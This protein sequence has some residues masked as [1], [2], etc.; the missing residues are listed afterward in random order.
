[1]TNGTRFMDLLLKMIPVW[2]AELLM[3]SDPLTHTLRN[4]IGQVGRALTSMWT[5]VAAACL[6]VQ[7]V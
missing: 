6:A 4:V 3:A 2:R 1:V 7:C 5:V